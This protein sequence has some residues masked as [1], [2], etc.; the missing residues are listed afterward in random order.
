MAVGTV[1]WFNAEKGYGFIAPDEGGNDAFVHITAVQRSGLQG[2]SEGAKVSYE[3]VEGRMENMLLKNKPCG[4]LI[5][6]RCASIVQI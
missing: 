3:L 1:K 2:L 4:R 5:P 6:F